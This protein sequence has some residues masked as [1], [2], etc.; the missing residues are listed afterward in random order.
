MLHCFYIIS[1]FHIYFGVYVRFYI[2][3]LSGLIENNYG[4]FN[5]DTN[6]DYFL[7]HE[8]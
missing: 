8:V 1:S 4:T 6:L 5:W 2:L 3:G 7:D